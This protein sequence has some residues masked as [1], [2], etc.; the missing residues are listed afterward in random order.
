M[1]LYSAL[2]PHFRPIWRPLPPEESRLSVALGDLVVFT[3]FRGQHFK[4]AES[5]DM[6][7][8]PVS[9]TLTRVWY[10][11]SSRHHQDHVP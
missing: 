5:C 9:L 7:K 11:P 10:Q 1:V 3:F 8:N 4:G 6:C 2:V